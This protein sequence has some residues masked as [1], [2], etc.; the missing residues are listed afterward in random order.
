VVFAET[1]VINVMS[2]IGKVESNS[3]D[4]FSDSI[5]WNVRWGVIEQEP[6]ENSCYV[7]E[8]L[9]ANSLEE[10]RINSREIIGEI[11][12]CLLELIF[13]FAAREFKDETRS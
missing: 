10:A 6:P 9:F 8:V 1:W 12:K 4:K 11:V 7:D 5:D 3:V 13:S 2:R